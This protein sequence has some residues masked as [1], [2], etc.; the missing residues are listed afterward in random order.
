MTQEDFNLLFSIDSLPSASTEMELLVWSR[1]YRLDWLSTR[2]TPEV[3]DSCISTHIKFLA[4]FTTARQKFTREQLRVMGWLI[5]KQHPYL[6]MPQFRAFI[7]RAMAG[8]FGKFYDKLDAVELL[9]HLQK[10]EQDLDQWRRAHW[11][12]RPQ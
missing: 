11:E 12:T 1:E 4:D 7:L 3:L 5:R 10:W 9:A 6:T 2:I 8:Y